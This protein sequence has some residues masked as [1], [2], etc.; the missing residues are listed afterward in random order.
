MS[1]QE[2]L[3]D[4]MLADVITLTNRPDLEAECSV[5]L[6]TATL[7]AHMGATY[8]R[9]IVT[10]TVQLPNASYLTSVDIQV[11]LPRCRGVSLVRLLDSTGSPLETPAIDVVEFGDIYD[12]LY[13]DLKSNIAYLAGTSLNVRSSV[14]ASGYSISY[15]QLPQVRRSEYNSWIAQLAPECIVYGA[16]AIVLSTN[17]NEEKAASYSKA[18][19]TL[20]K[21]QL[22][23]NF[24]TSAMR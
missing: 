16:A 4:A 7:S 6:R 14:P 9:D 11:L 5:A 2:E 12:P 1:M 24:Q 18:V 23:M 15:Y 10:A 19:A 13:G 17:G 8:L 21:P 3:Y 22:D 20:Y